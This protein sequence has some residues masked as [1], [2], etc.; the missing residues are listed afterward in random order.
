M[1]AGMPDPKSTEEAFVADAGSSVNGGTHSGAGAGAASVQQAAINN[2]EGLD[3]PTAGSTPS[4]QQAASRQ[5]PSGTV[6]VDKIGSPKFA[7]IY[8]YTL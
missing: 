7:K 2:D 6:A 3:L 5:D 4:A 1:K 8:Q